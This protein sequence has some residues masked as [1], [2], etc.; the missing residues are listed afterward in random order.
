MF[1]LPAVQ[2]PFEFDGLNFYEDYSSVAWTSCTNWV[3]S[4][5]G[6]LEYENKICFYDEV[7]VLFDGSTGDEC[8]CSAFGSCM[9]ADGAASF[10]NPV[11][12]SYSVVVAYRSS[13]GIATYF[14]CPVTTDL[15]GCR[16]WDPGQIN[17]WRLGWSRSRCQ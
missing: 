8:S 17:K 2:D 5:K 12:C 13:Y 9:Y 14:L 10:Y 7:F 16:V 1:D 15:V 4:W 6:V 3:E 11:S